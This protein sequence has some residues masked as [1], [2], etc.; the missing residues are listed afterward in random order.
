M[1]S[2]QQV[3]NLFAR[4]CEELEIPA[5]ICHQSIDACWDYYEQDNSEHSQRMLA[6]SIAMGFKQLG[7][8]HRSLLVLAIS[9]EMAAAC[10]VERV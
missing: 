6:D 9:T 10:A 2:Q 8:I 4:N 5:R 7:H 1:H 3:D